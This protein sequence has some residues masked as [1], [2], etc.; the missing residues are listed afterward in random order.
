LDQI[1][2]QFSLVVLFLIMN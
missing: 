1:I 2:M